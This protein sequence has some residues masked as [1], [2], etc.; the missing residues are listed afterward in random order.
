M[1][2]QK[3]G[4]NQNSTNWKAKH[5]MKWK[6]LLQTNR[7]KSNM[8]CQTIIKKCSRKVH[9]NMEKPFQVGFARPQKEFPMEYWC[10]LIEQADITLNLMQSCW[11]NTKCSAHEGLNGEFHFESTSIAL[12]GTKCLLHS[13]PQWCNAGALNTEKAFYFVPGATKSS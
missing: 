2:Y 9:H 8:H 10:Q 4:K 5:C 1:N 3:L 12:L 6:N 13:K 11:T 7:H